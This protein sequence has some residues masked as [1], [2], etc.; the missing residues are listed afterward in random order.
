MKIIRPNQTVQIQRVDDEEIMEMKII[1]SCCYTGHY[2]RV[3][4]QCGIQCG[5][6]RHKRCVRLELSMGVWVDVLQLVLQQGVN[7]QGLLVGTLDCS[8]LIVGFGDGIHLGRRHPGWKGHRH[9]N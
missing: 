1:S 9:A 6:G 3:K 7:N 8:T 4:G 2:I 5:T